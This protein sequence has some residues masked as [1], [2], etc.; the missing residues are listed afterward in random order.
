MMRRVILES[1]YAGDVKANVEYARKCM[2][3]CLR[4]G[5]A[6]FASHLLYTQCLDD[7]KPLER[8]LGIKAGL[9]WGMV[10]DL[11]VVYVDRGISGGMVQGIERAIAENRP[12]Q[13]RSLRSKC[14]VCQTCGCI[15]P[16]KCDAE[17]H[18]PR[19]WL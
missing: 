1:P 10:A 18:L 15:S 7:T 17:G 11:T 9:D 8:A 16:S 2:A 5:D 3:H 19:P 14:G 4:M 12:V 6:P 13:F